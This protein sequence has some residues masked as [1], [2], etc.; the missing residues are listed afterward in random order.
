[1]ASPSSRASGW[2]TCGAGSL[3]SP[4]HLLSRVLAPRV[5]GVYIDPDARKGTLPFDHAP[6]VIDLDLDA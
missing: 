2:R 5:V 3:T 1:M 6:V 4:H